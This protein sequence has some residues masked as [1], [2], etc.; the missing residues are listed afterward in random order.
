VE[1]EIF[2][3]SPNFGDGGQAAAAWSCDLTTSIPSANLTGEQPFPVN[4]VV[5]AQDQVDNIGAVIA[6][7]TLYEGF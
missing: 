6:V 7:P 4:V 1:L 5:L 3:P 2:C